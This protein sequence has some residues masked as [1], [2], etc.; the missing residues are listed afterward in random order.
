M[1]KLTQISAEEMIALI[2]ANGMIITKD[3]VSEVLDKRPYTT[4]R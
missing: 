4:L 3:S 2:A 1:N